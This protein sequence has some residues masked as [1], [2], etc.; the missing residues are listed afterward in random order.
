MAKAFLAVVFCLAFAPATLAAAPAQPPAPKPPWSQLTGAQQAVLAPLKEDWDEID[1]TRRKKW[2][3]IA[4]RYPRMK[5]DEQ[6]RLQARMR[7]WAKLSPEQRRIAREKY[8][9]LKKM[10]PDQREQV[11][12][13]WREYQQSLT[14][15]PDAASTEAA[16][17]APPQ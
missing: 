6:Q 4:D 3:G 13:Q 17:T 11:K 10:P 5:P 12:T 16:K 8:K 2:L 9:T 15:P 7:D 14:P 1:T